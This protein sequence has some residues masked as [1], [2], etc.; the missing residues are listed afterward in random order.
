MCLDRVSSQMF[1]M[2]NMSEFSID[3]VMHDDRTADSVKVIYWDEARDYTET[4]ILCQLPDDTADNPEEITLFGCTQYD[5]AWREGMYLAASNRERRQMVSWSTEM[6]GHIPTFGDL[7]WINH[8]LLGAGQMFSGTVAGVENDVLTLS[9]DC[10]L[11]TS[12]SPRDRTR[13]RMPSSA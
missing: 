1:S 12:P 10:L 9:Q 6:E 4:T 3:Y 8:D 5:Q 7:I 11:Y 2:A 13:S